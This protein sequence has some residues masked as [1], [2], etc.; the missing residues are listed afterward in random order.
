MT[1]KADS[2]GERLAEKDRRMEA[3]L[4]RRV[5]KEIND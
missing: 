1:H 3:T 4:D 2:Y 5:N